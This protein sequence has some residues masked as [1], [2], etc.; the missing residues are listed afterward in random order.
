MKHLETHVAQATARGE[1]AYQ[2]CPACGHTQA[3]ARPFCLAC[4]RPDPDWRLAR[5]TGTVVAHTIQH[6]APTDDWRSRVPYGVTLVDL[7][8]G[9]R[10][11]ALAE[12]TLN[13]GAR[14]IL[15]PGGRH[16]LPCFKPVEDG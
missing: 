11:M 6:R 1:I 10:V 5:N 13:P 15:C 2:H 16:A 14:A 9:P 12:G 8:E 4:L 7:D 3:Q